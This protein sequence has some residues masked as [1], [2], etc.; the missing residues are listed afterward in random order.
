MSIR[1]RNGEV[2]QPQRS[3]GGSLLIMYTQVALSDLKHCSIPRSGKRAAGPGERRSMA[4][5]L[6]LASTFTCLFLWHGY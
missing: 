1:L 6:D 4:S 2:L 3:K 5:V